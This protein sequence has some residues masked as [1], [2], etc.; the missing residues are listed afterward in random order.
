MHIIDAYIANIK[1]LIK[2]P[3]VWG[4]FVIMPAFMFLLF[5]FIFNSSGSSH[6]NIGIVIEDSGEMH[7]EILETF[8]REPIILTREGA[9]SELK[10]YNLKLVYL[11]EEDFSENIENNIKPEITKLYVDDSGFQMQDKFIN[12]KI[13]ALMEEN[14]LSANNLDKNNKENNID[15][16]VINNKTKIDM[17]FSMV[18]LTS[19]YI[20]ILLVSTIGTDIMEI[21]KKRVLGRMLTSPN[22]NFS[23]VF[24]LFL[25][26]FTILVI[27]YNAVTIFGYRLLDIENPNLLYTF[28][29]ISLISGFA[30]SLVFLILRYTKNETILSIITTMGSIFLFLWE[31]FYIINQAIFPNIIAK[32]LYLNPLYW[33]QMTMENG[34]LLYSIPIFLMTLVLL[35]FGSYKLENLQKI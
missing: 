1:R 9:E 15:I 28:V 3:K 2:S 18:I 10:K 7:E 17:S 33:V 5:F 32:L 19:C 27:M 34:N 8:E 16:K 35:T 13:T 22:T 20:I 26:Y 6:D 11:I 14:Y 4:M 29:L 30:L 31:M 23:N 21:I 25:S 24:A 12:D